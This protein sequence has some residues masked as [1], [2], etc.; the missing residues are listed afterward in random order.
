MART[1]G[2]FEAQFDSSL[3]NPETQKNGDWDRKYLASEFAKY[4]E[5]IVGNGVSGSTSDQLKVLSGN[6][7]VTV[8]PGYAFINGYWFYN[9]EDYTI[10]IPTGVRYDT[11]RLRYSNETRNIDF[12]YQQD[13]ES[14][15]PIQTESVYDLVLA[16]LAVSTSSITVEDL[17][18]IEQYCGIVN[19][20]K[21]LSDRINEKENSFDKNTAFNKNFGTTAGTVCEGND[22]RL[23]DSRKASD[24]YSWAKAATKPQYSYSEIKS[25]PTIPP[26]VAVKGENENTYRTGNVN[27]TRE[28]L[29]LKNV[30]NIGIVLQNT[31]PTSVAE[32]TI[33]LVYEE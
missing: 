28:N 16:R 5:M 21:E 19:N 4:F 29:G 7:Y 2:F 27:I 1:S 15:I 25:T 8:R 26:A 12:Y 23:S 31:V 22:A 30:T 3:L 6:G 24:V 13:D 32:G 14:A 9:S 17:R 11:V 20:P 33:V 18:S 10:P